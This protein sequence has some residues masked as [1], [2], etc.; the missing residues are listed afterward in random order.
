LALL[1]SGFLPRLP[2]AFPFCPLEVKGERSKAEGIREKE[3]EA[4]GRSGKPR[5][6]CGGGGAFTFILSP[7]TF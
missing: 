4:G 1:L 3:T 6:A 2:Q 5:I 7:F